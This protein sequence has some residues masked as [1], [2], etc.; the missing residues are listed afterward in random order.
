VTKVVINRCYGGFSLSEHAE[1]LYKERKGIT[2]KNWYY[3]DISR[4]D[5][6]LVQIVEELGA[7]ADGGYA[8]LA[9]VDIPDEVEWQVEEYDGKEWVAEVHR[10]WY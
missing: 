3:W 7:S 5:P 6:V 4:D 1:T 8:E 2:D 10:T 9:V